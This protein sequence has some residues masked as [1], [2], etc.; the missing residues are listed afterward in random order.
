MN[1]NLENESGAPE[2]IKERNLRLKNA[3]VSILIT[4]DRIQGFLDDEY[5]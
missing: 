3:Y 5:L 4:I 1:H 2:Y